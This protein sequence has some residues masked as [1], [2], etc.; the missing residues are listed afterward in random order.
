MSDGLT[1]A[2]AQTRAFVPPGASEVPKA[3]CASATAPS[4]LP[5]EL[6]G[7]SS[8]SGITANSQEFSCTLKAKDVKQVA[9]IMAVLIVGVTGSGIVT[10]WHER[11]GNHTTL[12]ANL[13]EAGV[14][15]GITATTALLAHMSGVKAGMDVH[16]A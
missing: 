4:W 9:T 2:T 3:K 10:T 5:D 14:Q 7:P 13:I 11:S 6:Q 12:A 15:F 16:K 8:G 1:D